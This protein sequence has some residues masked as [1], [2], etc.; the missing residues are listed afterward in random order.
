MTSKEKQKLIEEIDNLS[1]KLLEIAD[2]IYNNPEQGHEEHKAAAKLTE[3]LENQ[4]FNIERGIAGLETSFKATYGDRK[5]VVAILAEYDALPEGHACGHN[6]IA[7]MAVGAAIALK[8][9][10][11]ELQGRV[12]VFGTPAEETD[13]AKVTMVEQGVFD[14]IDAAMMIHPSDKNM[15]LDTS[16]AMDAIEFTYHGRSA[17]ASAAPHDGIN[18]LDAVIQLFNSINALRQ[19]LKEDV[20]IHGIITEGGSAPN[21]IPKKAVARFYVRAK[22]RNYLDEVVEKVLNCANGAASA[23][24]CKLEHRNF[25]LSFDNMITNK[26]MSNLF[27]ENLEALGEHLDPPSKTYGSTDMGNVSHVAPA[28]HPYIS[29][30]DQEIAAHTQEFLEAAGSDRGKQGMITGTKVMA[31]TIYDLLTQPELLERAKKEFEKTKSD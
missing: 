14:D 29:I 4:G 6:L 18:A 26:V 23:T 19:Q 12:D 5:P 3:E 27:K 25:E 28:V 9:H 21:I 1:E 17:H 31:L 10:Q 13:G 15:I 16:L 24:G 8:N 22:D 20:R 11:K 2:Y 7:A 30:S